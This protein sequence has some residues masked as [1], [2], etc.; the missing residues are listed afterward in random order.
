M[1]ALL[2]YKAASCTYDYHSDIDGNNFTRWAEERLIPNLDQSGVNVM[3]N[4]SYH[5][6]RTDIAQPQAPG[7][8]IQEFFGSQSEKS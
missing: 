5:S 8:H 6:T 3:D 4:A 2:T 1:V 7:R